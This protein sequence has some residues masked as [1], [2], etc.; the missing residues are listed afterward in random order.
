MNCIFCNNIADTSTVEHILPE[1]LGGKEWAILPPGLVCTG[2]NQYFGS[3]VESLALASFP[4]LPFRLLLGV[5]TKH[6]KPPKMQ[7]HLGTA[8][9]SLFPGQIGLDPISP[10]VEDAIEQGRITQ[11]RILAEPTEALAVCRLLLKMGLEVVASDSP[12]AVYNSK[13]D[14]ARQFART[15]SRNTQWWFLLYANHEKLFERFSHGV[16]QKDWA[17]GVRL[18]ITE[19]E[20]AEVFH[21]KLLDM[22]LIT[23]LEGNVLPPTMDGLPEPEYRLFNVSC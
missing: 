1:S 4:F 16:S 13:F 18:E 22:D 7:T 17:E 2:C 21:L 20:G 5:P 14:L 11:L 23:P 6:D 10:E 9:S 12:K 19:V 15:P 3:K 8:K